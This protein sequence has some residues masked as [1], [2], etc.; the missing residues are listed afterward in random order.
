MEQLSI[1]IVNRM[2][3]RGVILEEDKQFYCYS[4]Q[5]LLEKAICLS[6]IFVLS[7]YFHIVFQVATFL[8]I[9]TTIRRFSDGYHCET[10]YG[11]LFA[12]V[13]LCL[14]TPQFVDLID[15]NCAIRLAGVAVAVIVLCIIANSDNPNLN[16]TREELYHLKRK[17]RITVSVIG[18]IVVLTILFFPHNE[19][20]S[21][22]A[23]GIIYN[24]ISLLIA[25]M[26]E[27][28]ERDDDQI[29]D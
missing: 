11:C 6:L 19:Y 12:S 13:L 29:S 1:C 3:S 20:V 24:A 27:G 28:R 14:S 21:Y 16:L 9:F 10:A 4:V 8:V 22:M 18:G 7:L 23:L 5:T 17:S 26:I 2:A 15:D 25:T